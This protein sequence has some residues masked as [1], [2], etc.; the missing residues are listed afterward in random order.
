VTDSVTTSISRV[1]AGAARYPNGEASR[2][3]A[4][5]FKTVPDSDAPPLKAW[6]IEGMRKIAAASS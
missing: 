5:I 3:L 4:M 2:P 1:G 6:E